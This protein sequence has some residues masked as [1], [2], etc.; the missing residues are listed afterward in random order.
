MSSNEKVDLLQLPLPQLQNLRSQMEEVRCG[1]WNDWATSDP[2]S[3]SSRTSPAL[4]DP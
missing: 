2:G 4:L 1:A 3:R